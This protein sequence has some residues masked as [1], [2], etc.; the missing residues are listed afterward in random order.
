MPIILLMVSSL[1][2]DTGGVTYDTG[3]G[4]TD[5][6]SGP[7]DTGDSS[8]WDTGGGESGHDSGSCDSGAQPEVGIGGA[9]EGGYSTPSIL[10]TGARFTS[11]YTL[12]ASATLSG[13]ECAVDMGGDGSFGVCGSVLG[14]EACV[15]G[16]GDFQ[17]TCQTPTRCD[18]G[19][20]TCS[21]DDACCS[22]DANVAIEGSLTWAKVSGTVGVLD[23][24]A[25]LSGSVDAKFSG[26]GAYGG[27]CECSTGVVASGDLTLTLTAT[28]EGQVSA[29][30]FGIKAGEVD[31]KIEA[32]VSVTRPVQLGCDSG[33]STTGETQSGAA[34][35]INAEATSVGWLNVGAYSRTYS[36]GTGC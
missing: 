5:T 15:G 28:G 36:A 13:D 24:S 20:L 11:S 21:F 19:Q 16:D 35:K 27:G 34:V 14:K 29:S 18:D 30:M 17:A 25:S 12:T 32:C 9:S 10:G 2:A 6:G 4:P 3:G 1:A 33:D 31:A 22:G 8:A 23:Y 7:A 26:Q